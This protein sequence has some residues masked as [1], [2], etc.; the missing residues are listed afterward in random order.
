MPA[1][2]VVL[3][4]G[5]VVAS[6]SGPV[7]VN[8]TAELRQRLGMVPEGLVR[9][10]GRPGGLLVGASAAWALFVALGVV[11]GVVAHALEGP[12]DKP[13]Y[14]WQKS[15]YILPDSFVFH[16]RWIG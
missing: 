5:L 2:A 6:V 1:T 7:L 16:S 9:R 12:I 8:G 10:M 13:V 11:F 14:R 3:L 15:Q 4:V